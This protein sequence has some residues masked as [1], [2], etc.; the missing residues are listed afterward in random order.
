[1]S[2]TY[3]ISHV[4]ETLIHIKSDDSGAMMDL[5]EHYTFYVDGYKFMPS[6]R[7]KMWDGKIRLLN[8][9]NN[10][11]PYGLLPKTLSFAKDSGYG[12]N[13][14]STLK[15]KEVIDK[16]YLDKFANSQELRAGGKKIELRDYQ[17]DAFIHGI[18]EGR[19][20]IVS[21]TGSGKSLIIYMYIKW[22][23]EN[24]DDNVLIR[25]GLALSSY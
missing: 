14:C 2:S 19:S 4:D 13:L 16:D 17:Y 25:T 9:R 22:Y 7:N 24:H 20:L 12:I 18:T 15:N 3:D 6:Y 10:T 5:S 21:P 23:I 1:M 11:L 8:M